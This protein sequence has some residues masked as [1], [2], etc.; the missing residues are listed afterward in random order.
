MEGNEKGTDSR[1]RE[2]ISRLN[3]IDEKNKLLQMQYD[4][5]ETQLHTSKTAQN[6]LQ[7]ELDILHEKQHKTEL[8]QEENISFELEQKTRECLQ[9]ELEIK[10]L[11][12][13]IARL[14]EL[15]DKTRVALGESTTKC[16]EIQDTLR[17]EERQNASLKINQEQFEQDIITYKQKIKTLEIDIINKQGDE[18]R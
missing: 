7:I 6:N 17:R 16:D 3:E 11:K 8:R 10:R 5:L 9:R 2:A 14:S 4:D 12:D 13:E 15:E 1:L 18:N